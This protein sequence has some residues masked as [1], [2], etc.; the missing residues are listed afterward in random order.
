MAHSDRSL[1]YPFGPEDLG[2]LHSITLAGVVVLWDESIPRSTAM[3][4]KPSGIIERTV[5]R[6]KGISKG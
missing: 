6:R 3:M 4:K 5:M 2:N 1:D